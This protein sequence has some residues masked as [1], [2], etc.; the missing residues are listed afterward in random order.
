MP[1]VK[2]EPEQGCSAKGDELGLKQAGPPSCRAV[3][4]L[5]APAEGRWA[6]MV[7]VAVTDPTTGPQLVGKGKE[8]DQVPGHA[9]SSSQVRS[10]RR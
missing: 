4:P 5:T 3:T 10:S 1:R 2:K 7:T 8:R 6:R 9:R